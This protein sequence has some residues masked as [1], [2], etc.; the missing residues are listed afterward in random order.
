M[1]K[2]RRKKNV[3]MRGSK[4]HGWGAMKKHRGAGHRGGRGR[5][6]SGKRGDQKKPSYWKTEKGGSK[7]FTS[8]TRPTLAVNLKDI[9]QRLMKL[10]MSGKATRQG[11][12]YAI[13]IGQLGFG[14]LTGTGRVTHKFAITSGKASSHAKRKVE[15]AGGTVTLTAKHKNAGAK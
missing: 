5:S 8:R 4:T 3:R 10:V 1:M 7:G 6:G 15:E 12:L 2:F 13:D 9:E 14:K 11:D